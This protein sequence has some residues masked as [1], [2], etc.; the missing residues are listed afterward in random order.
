[1]AEILKNPW[2]CSFMPRPFIAMFSLKKLPYNPIESKFKPYLICC[3]PKHGQ[4]WIIFG[5][6]W[7]QNGLYRGD[8]WCRKA[9]EGVYDS[10]FDIYDHPRPIKN[11][12]WD[13]GIIIIMLMW[14][15]MPKMA[16]LTVL[17]VIVHVACC[18]GPL[19]TDK[20]KFLRHPNNIKICFEMLTLLIIIGIITETY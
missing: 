11:M 17:R 20:F 2:G 8:R 1:M 6:S 3:T 10:K 15:K 5:R 12:L 19:K 13:T 14:S 18:F 9:L 4:K 7:A 16:I